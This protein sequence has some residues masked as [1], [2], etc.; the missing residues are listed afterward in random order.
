MLEDGIE[1]GARFEVRFNGTYEF[2]KSTKT[3]N[4]FA[5]SNF[6]RVECR[7]QEF[8]RLVVRLQ[9]NRKWVAVFSSV[10][11]RET[12]R[13]VEAAGSAVDHFRHKRERLK[14]A[15]SKILEQQQF[16]E[17]VQLTLIR[18]RQHCA[19]SFEVN[20]FLTDLV[21]SRQ[22]EMTHSA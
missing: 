1:I 14:R 17:I 4:L 9:G 13:I 19:E 21:M 16:R 18:D 5:V 2:F 7:P 15:R 3:I 12:R 8:Y 22:F 10:R 6:R 20:V 11:K